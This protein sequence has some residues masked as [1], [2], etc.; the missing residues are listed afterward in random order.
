MQVFKTRWFVRFAR[1][2][3]IANVSL[4]EA[5]APPGRNDRW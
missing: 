1:S 3:R 4:L 5:I 2:E